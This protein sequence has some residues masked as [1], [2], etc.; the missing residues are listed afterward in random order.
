SNSFSS[1]SI[2]LTSG[3]LFIYSFFVNNVWPAKKR[4]PTAQYRAS[5]D[6][7]VNDTNKIIIGDIKPIIFICFFCSGE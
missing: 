6:G 4:P 3:C 5:A 7:A 1:C 2:I